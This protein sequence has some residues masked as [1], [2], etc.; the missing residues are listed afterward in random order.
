MNPTRRTFLQT[1]AAALALTSTEWLAA[2]A[3]A[4]GVKFK[5]SAPDWSLSQECKL[6]AVG[7]SKQIG[8]PG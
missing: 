7:L 8:F 4:K 1:G 3:A 5:L 6:D 2:Y